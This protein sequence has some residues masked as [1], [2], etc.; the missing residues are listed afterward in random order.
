MPLYWELLDNR[1]GN[2]N[3]AQR[4]AVL[5]VC[6]A[7]LGRERISLVLGDRE[8][9][10]YVWLK[11]FKDN[12]LNFVMR[13]PKHHL[14][15][16]ESDGRYAITDL[17]LAAG[18]VRRVAYVQIDGIWGQVWV[19]AL[20]DGEFLF[21]FGTSGLRSLGQF[22]AKRWTI[23]LCFQDLKGRKFDL[24]NSHLRYYH[25]L[26]KLVALVSLVS[27]FCLSVG[28]AADQRTPVARKNH[29]YR[30]TSLSRHG[31]NIVRQLTRPD[32]DARIK[33]ARTV[34]ALLN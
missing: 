6:V 13:L 16:D 28:R 19:N 14:L 34:E 27:A 4:L 5:E 9:V 11:Y 31:L 15:T 10:G 8:F 29:G 21:L 24:K 25:K 20:A 22:Y 32:T 2:S 12:E 33:L 7:V 26:R 1:S 30:A 3:A 23:E 18:Q 17:G